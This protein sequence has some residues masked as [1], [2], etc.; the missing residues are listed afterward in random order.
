MRNKLRSLASD[1][2]IYGMATIVS[3]FLTF[4]LTPLYTNYMLQADVGDMI[5]LNALIP[6]LN[7]VY[8]FGMEASFFRFYK[9][10]DFI[11]SQK[12]FTHSFIVI[13]IIS[14]FV[15]LTIFFSSDFLA[16]FLTSNPNGS[17]YI[18]LLSVVPFLD[19]LLIVPFS[20]MRMKRK[21]RK[22]ALYKLMQVIIAV[23]F[24]IVFVVLMGKGIA[25]V[26]WS[27]LI[28][29]AF[30]FLICLP[31][32]VRYLRFELDWPLLKQMLR[33]GVP[34]IPASFSS[35]V[36]QVADKPIMKAMANSETLA[37]YGINYKLGIPMMMLVTMFEYAWKPF[38]LT[39]Y[40][41]ADAKP[42]F[43]RVLTYFTL[44]S[45]IVFLTMS[46]FI[47]DI[48]DLP[49]FGKKFIE[50]SYWKG[51]GIIPIILA[52]YYFNGVF[53]NFA[54]GFY[55]RKKTD[56]LPLVVGA[57][58]ALNIAMNILLIPST[59]IWGAAWATFAA[60]FLNAVLLYYFANRI[61]PLPYEW[62][63]V[64]IIIGSTLA[65]YFSADYILQFFDGYNA[66]L[67]KTAAIAV[68]FFLLQALGFFIPSE[69]RSIKK[70]FSRH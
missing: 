20:L 44:L 30:A 6:F 60:Y 36:L 39:H 61:Y 7:I 35:M 19:S 55:I 3:R 54:A 13:G 37:V 11:D 12:V 68:F 58:A 53:T 62:K 15:S 34:T 18:K 49:F 22:F 2:A 31:E 52:G 16:S 70:L 43:A 40:E 45:S 10:N 63:R 57:G 64:F 48:V 1:T 21:V 4:M 42:L 46:L 23:G 28:A 41:D 51:L 59:G 38:Y 26:F 65:V 5:N 29:S 47:S 32:I 25:G 8:S 17:Y 14:F 24:N 56:Y 66:L 27:L 67:I 33:F 69:I 50:P 9:Q